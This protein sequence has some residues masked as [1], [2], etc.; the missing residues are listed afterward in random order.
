MKELLKTKLFYRDKTGINLT[1]D[2]RDL[3][4]YVENSYNSLIAGQKMIY[5]NQNLDYGSIIIGAPSHIASFYLMKYI[6]SFRKDHPNIFIRIISGSTSFLIEELIQHKI[7]FIIDSSPIEFDFTNLV[8]EKLVSF[9]TCFIT[10]RIELLNKQTINLED[11][12]YIMP[13]ERSSIRKNLERKLK[14]NNQKLHVVLEVE[15]T[16]LIIDAVKNDVGI[17]YVVKESVLKEIEKKELFELKTKHELP[18]LELNLVYIND[19]L[20]NSSK[21]IINDYIKK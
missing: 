17:G 15:T 4:K 14:Q 2:G 21:K 6:K 7:D 5:E 18:E 12:N 3:L 10:N 19:Y 8:I 9:K 1:K 16:E 11:Y 20:T 13:Y